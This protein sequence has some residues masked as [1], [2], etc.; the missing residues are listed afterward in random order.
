MERILKGHSSSVFKNVVTYDTLL[1]FRFCSQGVYKTKG[2]KNQWLTKIESVNN[3][4]KRNKLKIIYIGT[5]C[6][7]IVHNLEQVA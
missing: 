7:L 4:L 1:T 5:G 3:K 2:T 6:K